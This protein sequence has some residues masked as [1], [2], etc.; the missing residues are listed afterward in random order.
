MSFRR[1]AH[2]PQGGPDGGDGG[3]GGD[4]VLVCSDSL[5]DLQSFKRKAHYKAARGRH[6]EGSN[7]YGA[8]GDDLVVGVPP[9]TQVTTE[10]GTLYDLVVPGQRVVVARGGTGGRGHKRFATPPPPAPPVAPKG[11]P[12][13]EQRRAARPE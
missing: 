4:V 5:R 3:H 11:P 6:G 13:D 1:E 10:D 7:R 8:E 12:R 2:V 9:G